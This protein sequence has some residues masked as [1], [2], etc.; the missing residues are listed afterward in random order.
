[1]QLSFLALGTLALMLLFSFWIN[2]PVQELIKEIDKLG[3]AG[4]DHTVRISGPEE[5]AA[6][7]RKLDW[8]R[9]RLHETDKQ[10]QHK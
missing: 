1:M 3:T 10:K 6:L 7:G 8:L 5:V 4:L 2:K 9:E